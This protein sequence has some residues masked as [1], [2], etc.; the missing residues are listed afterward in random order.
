MGTREQRALQIAEYFC[1]FIDRGIDLSDYQ[2]TVA[3]SEALEKYSNFN[4]LMRIFCE[5]QN[6][7]ALDLSITQ[8]E[9]EI[10]VK[11]VEIN[12]WNASKIGSKDYSI[13]TTHTYKTAGSLIDSLQKT[14]LFY[15]KFRPKTAKSLAP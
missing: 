12:I 15:R 3:R 8:N 13:S 1:D 6:D 11:R 9:D 5:I 7:V 14:I 4:G 10:G 2:Y